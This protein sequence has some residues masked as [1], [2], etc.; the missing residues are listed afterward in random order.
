MSRIVVDED[1]CKGCLLCTTVCPKS[2]LHQSSRM[3]RKGYLVAEMTEQGEKNCIACAAC[4]QICPD[5]AISVFKTRKP[6]ES[7]A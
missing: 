6:K 3:N 2:I 4:A 7:A 1:L 5:W